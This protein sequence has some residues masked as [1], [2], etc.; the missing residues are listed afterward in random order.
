MK[1]SFII[2]LL[3]LLYG[4]TL[5][6]Q[7][8]GPKTQKST[9]FN[10]TQVPSKPKIAYSGPVAGD[11]A[12]NE[13]YHNPTVDYMQSTNSS[14]FCTDKDGKRK[15]RKGSDPVRFI[16]IK[17]IGT[18]PLVLYSAKSSCGCVKVSYPQDPI[19]QG[20][21]TTLEIHYDTFRVGPFRKSIEIV[22]NANNPKLTIFLSGEVV[23]N[24]PEC[25]CT[26]R[27]PPHF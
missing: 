26:K 1:K 6:A 18:E 22:T 8:T 25:P 23:D 4:S 15:M 14:N 24:S 20:K 3:G 16:T 21:T 5:P 9:T 17:N 11:P 10:P 7:Q 27:K 19:M 12:T 2:I 13:S